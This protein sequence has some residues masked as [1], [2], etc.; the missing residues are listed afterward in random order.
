MNTQQVWSDV[1]WRDLQSFL[2]AFLPSKQTD[3]TAVEENPWKLLAMISYPYEII[4][5][6][7]IARSLCFH[8]YS[9]TVDL[10]NVKLSSIGIS[11]F[12]NDGISF[13]SN[14]RIIKLPELRNGNSSASFFTLQDSL[15]SDHQEDCYSFL[16]NVIFWDT[17]LFWSSGQGWIFYGVRNNP[18]PWLR[19][20]ADR[21]FWNC[22]ENSSILYIFP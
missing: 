10:Q 9:C 19:C 18:S 12:L 8:K 4:E 3:S 5:H 7:S 16:D 13:A 6:Q 2:H 14:S 15:S 11:L 22:L 20:K 1:F 21:Y 17:D